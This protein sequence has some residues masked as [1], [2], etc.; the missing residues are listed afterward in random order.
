VDYIE[1]RESADGDYVEVPVP[2]TPVA[3]D[4]AQD[5]ASKTQFVSFHTFVGGRAQLEY[6]RHI[7]LLDAKFQPIGPQA[8]NLTQYLRQA[9]AANGSQAVTV[10][11]PQVL[12]AS[13]GKGYVPANYALPYT[14]NATNP[15]QGP[16]GEL[17]IVT[18]LDADL[19]VRSLRLGD[20]KIGNINVHLPD[21]QAV[22]QGDFDFTGNLGLVLRVSAGIDAET[23]VATWLIQAIDP[24]T[25]EVLHDPVRGLLAPDS[26]NAGAQKASVSYTVQASDLA[27]TGAQ[28]SV[29]ARALFDGLPPQDS[30]S[31]SLTLDAKAP[32]T[33]LSAQFAGND[34]QGGAT[35]DVRW[36]AVDDA[37]GVKH[38]TVYVAEEGGD[39]RIWRKQVAGAAGNA[40]FT[41][42]AGKHYEFLA[43]ATDLA[44]NREAA[45]VANA[46]LP[47]D[48]SQQA[49][50]TA[51]GVLDTVQGSATLP[52]AAPGRSY[53]TNSLFQS[54]SQA[55]PGYVAT[56]QPA[57]LQSVLAPLALRGLASGFAASEADIGVQA[58]VELPDGS[59]LASAGSLR[60]QV[61]HFDKAGGRSTT[62]LFELDS[63]ILDLALDA[64]GQLWAMTGSEL[65]Q[66]DATSGA[67]LQ[68]TRSS[69]GDPLT[70]ALAI[71]PASGLFYVSSGNGVETYNAATGAWTHFSNTRVIDLAF[72]PDGRLW[73]VRSTGADV[74]TG[75]PG[76]TTELISFPMSGKLKGRA[77]VEYTLAGNVQAIAFGQA[78]TPLAGL[79]LASTATPQRPV[80]TDGENLPHT[81]SLWAIEL[82]SHRLLKLASG[83]TRQ[84]ALVATADGRILV[85]ES[86]RIDEIA[87]LKAPTVLAA[88]VADGSVL[89]LPLNQVSIV[90]DQAM[91]LGDAGD[92]SE[93]GSVLNPANYQLTATGTNAGLTLA[94]TAVR[95]DA[96]NHAVVLTLP[97]LAAGGWELDV[98]NQLLSAAG[99]P[100]AAT[101]VS[102]FTAVVDMSNA[103]SIAFSNTRANRATGEVSYD[104]SITNIGVDDIHGPL[105]LLLDPGR[106]FGGQIGNASALT[107]DQSDLWLI[108]LSTG[109]TGLGGKLAVGATLA[110]QTVSVTPASYFGTGVSGLAK[111]NLG[112]GLYAVPY[113]NTP[114]ALSNADLDDDTGVTLA[115]ATLGQPY[116]AQLL[117]TDTDG[118]QF[119]W[120][121][122]QGPAGLTLTPGAVVH[123]AD[124]S[125]SQTAELAWTPGANA[126]ANT[127]VLVRV[128]DSRGGTDLKR[129]NI[130]VPGGN[131]AP[132]IDAIS[133]ITLTEGQSL[134]QRLTASDANGD[135]LS[136]TVRNLPAG[137]RFNAATGMLSWTPSYDQAGD[138]RDV[139]VVVSD[140]KAVTTR[141]FNIHVDQGYPQPVLA[142]VPA[143][144][145][146][147]GDRFGLQLSGQV[148]G[149]LAHADGS[150]ITLSFDATWLP[151]GATLNSETGWFEWTPGYAQAGSYDVPISLTATFTPAD[152][153]EPVTTSVASVLHLSVANANG[154]PVFDPVETWTVLEGQALRVSLF[155]FDPDNPGFAPKVRL[156][157]TAPAVDSEGSTAAS[158]SYSVTGLPPGASFD[159]DTLELV[160]TPGYSQA[161][162]Y[163]IN[164]TATD[165]GNGIGVPLSSHVT[166]PITVLNANR[167]PDI[168]AI[169][170]ATLDAGATLDIPVSATDADGN[171]I[172]LTIN[173]LPSF[174]T[175]TQ[176]ANGQGSLHFAPPAGVRGDYTVT[177]VANDNGDGDPNQ[178]QAQSVSFVLTVRSL[179]MPPRFTLPTSVVAVAGQ[180]LSLP[181]QVSDDDQDALSIIA[182]GLPTGAQLVRNAQYGSATLSWTPTAA[183]LGSYNV[184]IA[185]TDSGLPPADNGTILDPAFVP[186]PNTTAHDLRI[187]VRAANAAASLIA[188]SAT[189]ATLDAS[190]LAG[191]TTRVAVDEGSAMTFELVARDPDLDT[192]NWTATGLPT[193]MTLETTPGTDG[194]SQARLRWT[195]GIFGAQSGPDSAHPGTYTITLTA[196]DGNASVSRTLELTVRNVNQA[197]IVLPMP[198]QLVQEGQT[199]S[200]TVR[201]Y[202]ADGDATQL[203]LVHDAN[204]PAGVSFDAGS[205]TFEWT[206][207]AGIVNN[208]QGNARN[209][210]FNF[211]ISDGSVTTTRA[212]QVRVL[213][214]N[215]PPM[216][217]ASSHALVVGQS[218][219]LPVQKLKRN[220]TPLAGAIQVSDA[221][222][223][224]QTQTLTVAFENLPEGASFDAASG[225]LRW[226]PGPGQVGDFVVLA[227]VSDGLN[228]SLES[229]TLRVVANDDAALRANSPKV[230][231]N[232]TPATPALP[233]QTVV[234]TVRASSFSAI[235]NV[236]VQVRGS[237]LGDALNWQPA[238]LDST[239][240]LK[241]VPTL[242]GLIEVLVTA[243]DADSFTTTQTQTVRV[244]DP[245]DNAA[246]QLAWAG[247]L[248]GA[249]L[250]AAP[251]NLQSLTALQA[252]LD[253]AQLMGWR[254]EIASATGGSTDDSSWRLLAQ[255]DVAAS[256][257]HSVLDLASLDPSLLA[258][259]VYALRLSAWDL[260]GRTTELQGRVVIDS[261][262]KQLTQASATD[263][264]FQLG[265]HRFDL[266]RSL[267]AGTAAPG[268]FGNWTLPALSLQLSHDQ[269]FTT[270]L[271][272]TAPWSQGARVWLQMPGSADQALA[273]TLG[274]QTQALGNAPGTPTTQHPVFIAAAGTPAG[275]TLQA[276]AG[277]TASDGSQALADAASVMPDAVQHQG[278]R[279]FDADSGL[280]W[281]P[282]SYW[283]TGPDGTRYSLDAQGRVT[284]MRF[285]DGQAWIVSDAGLTLA[286]AGATGAR[287][288]FVRNA[289]GQIEQV[290]GQDAQGNTHTIVYRY[291]AQGRL[292]L[293]REL[294]AAGTGNLVGYH[295]DGSLIT[296]AVNVNF[297]AAVAWQGSSPSNAWSGALAS[298]PVNFAYVVRDSE[299]ASTV[300]AAG[301]EGSIVLALAVQGGGAL[302]LTQHTGS[303]LLA[304][305]TQ[306]GTTTYLLRTTQAGMQ[307]LSLTG[308]GAAQVRISV[309]GD[310][311]Q[312]GRVDGSDSA[313]FELAMQAGSIATV[314]L[315]GDG[316]GN[317]TDR[318]VLYA[319]YG[320]RANQAPF[321]SPDAGILG[322]HANL[323]VDANG[324]AVAQDPE[325]DRLFW[326]IL[327]ATHGTATL[328][329]DGRTI[330]FNPEAGYTGDAEVSLQ[331][332]DGYALSAPIVLKVRVSAAPLLNVQVDR[333]VSIGVGSVQAMR[334]RGDYADERGV[335]LPGGYAQITSDNT[336]V[337]TVD[338]E[339]YLHGLKP[340]I[341]LITVRTGGLTA[342]NVVT[343]GSNFTRPNTD[344]NGNEL[345]LYPGSIDL[346][347]NGGQ[348]QVDVHLLDGSYLGADVS[349][350][351]AGTRY[352]ISDPRIADISPDGNVV[353]KASGTATITVVRGG[354]QGRIELRVHAANVGPTVA[355]I[356][357]GVVTQDEQG[358]T[359]TIGANAL[360]RNTMAS[361]HA[362][363]FSDLSTPLPMSD[364]LPAL[365][366]VQVDLQGA[367]VSVPLQ[368]AIK[369][370]AGIDPA[371][372]RPVDLAPG[373]E[374]L[375]WQEG[376]VRGA[377]GV[378]HNVW[379]LVDNGFI[380]NDGIA[381]TASPPYV[382]AKGDGKFIVTGTPAIDHETGAQKIPAALVNTTAW[383][384]AAA[385][386][387]VA[388]N[389]MMAGA[390]LSI[391]A[392]RSNV[393]ALTYT[394]EGAYQVQIPKG[395]LLPGSSVSIPTPPDLPRTTPAVTQVQYNPTSREL[396]VSGVNFVPPGQAPENFTLK[397]WLVPIGDQIASVTKPGTAPV[398]GLIWQAFDVTPQPDGSLHLVLPAGVALSQHDVYVERA[399]NASLPPGSKVDPVIVK[400]DPA[401]PTKPQPPNPEVMIPTKSTIA[402]ASTTGTNLGAANLTQDAANAA[403][404]QARSVWQAQGVNVSVLDNVSIKLDALSGNALAIANGNVITLSSDAAH[405]GWYV[406]ADAFN[407]SNF[408]E[409][410]PGS[411]QLLATASSA[412][413]GRIDL[414]TTL[415]EQVGG[416]LGISGNGSAESVMNPEL[417][418]GVRRLP[419]ASDVPPAAKGHPA[420]AV[421]LKPLP[422]PTQTPKADPTPTS[423]AYALTHTRAQEAPRYS[424]LVSVAPT[425]PSKDILVTTADTIDIFQ[426]ATVADPSANPQPIRI[427]QVTR[428][429]QGRKLELSGNYA[430]QI[431]FSDDGSLAFIAGKGNRIYVF[432]T[433]T[434]D[435]VLTYEVAGATTA[436]NSL[437][438]NGE[439]LYIAEGSNYGPGGGRLAR[440]NI[441]SGPEFFKIFQSLSIPGAVAPLGFRDMAVNSGRYLAITAPTMSTGVTRSFAGSR[442]NVYLIDLAGVGKSSTIDIAFVAQLDLSAYPK[443][444]LGKGPQYITSASGRGQFLLSDSKDYDYGTAA[445]TFG[446]S[447]IDGTPQ[448]VATVLDP[449]LVPNRPGWLQNKYQQNIQ[450]SA[451][452]VTLNYAGKTY[453]LVADYNFAW[454]D[455]HASNGDAFGHQIGGKIGVIEDPFGENGEPIYLGATTP[456][457]GVALDH[458]MLDQSGMLYVDGFVEDESGYYTGNHASDIMYRSLFV[459]NASQL[460][461]AA[462]NAKGRL[463]TIPID[464]DGWGPTSNQYPAATPARYDTAG[465]GKLFGWIYGV[466]SYSSQ[467]A[468]PTLT[469]QNVPDLKALAPSVFRTAQ[470]AADRAHVPATPP[471]VIA[472]STF[473]TFAV[474][475]MAQLVAFGSFAVGSFQAALGKDNSEMMAQ[476]SDAQLILDRVDYDTKNGGWTASF[477]RAT[478]GAL[479]GLMMLPTDFVGILARDTALV[480]GLRTGVTPK[481]PT[482]TEFLQLL[483]SEPSL[484]EVIN[485]AAIATLKYHPI[486]LGV[487]TIYR[488]T[489]AAVKKDWED[490]RNATAE[491]FVLGGLTK[492]AE[493]PAGKR[494]IQLKTKQADF[495][496]QELQRGAIEVTPIKDLTVEPTGTQQYIVEPPKV[497]GSGKV[498]SEGRTVAAEEFGKAM[499]G[500]FKEGPD[501]KIEYNPRVEPKE[502]IELK[503]RAKEIEDTCFDGE[504]LVHIRLNEETHKLMG[505]FIKTDTRRSTDIGVPLQCEIWHLKPGVE[506]LSKC[507]A[508]GEVAYRKITRVYEHASQRVWE[509]TYYSEHFGAYLSLLVTGN[510]PFWVVGKGWVNVIDLQDGD[511]FITTDGSSAHFGSLEEYEYPDTVYNIEVE[512]FHTYF[513]GAG[514]LVHNK[515]QTPSVRPLNKSE[516][517]GAVAQD[518]IFNGKPHEM[519]ARDALAQA[520]M[521]NAALPGTGEKGPN[522]EKSPKNVLGKYQ[523]DAQGK[524][525]TNPDGS[526]KAGDP[527]IVFTETGE[528]ADLYSPGVEGGGSLPTIAE[529]VIKK[530]GRQASTI[531]VDLR[532][533]DGVAAKDV[534]KAVDEYAVDENGNPA[535]PPAGL[536]RLIIIEKDGA[537]FI[538]EYAGTGANKPIFGLV[539]LGTG[540]TFRLTEDPA[541]GTKFIYDSRIGDPLPEKISP[542][543]TPLLESVPLPDQVA[544]QE[545]LTLTAVQELFPAARQY[546]LAIGASET[547]LDRIQIGV[548]RLPAGQAGMIEGNQITLSVDGAG[549]GWF[550]DVTPTETEEFLS[551]GNSQDFTADA[552]SAAAGK[553]DL[554][555]VLIHEM[556]HALGLG[557]SSQAG[558]VMNAVLT[559]GER[560][561]PGTDDALG[562]RGQGAFVET[563]RLF[564]SRVATSL[565]HA[566]PAA[567]PQFELAA[568]PQ[569]TNG[570]FGGTSAAR[571]TTSGWTTSGLVMANR[572]VATLAEGAVS[573]TQLSQ[574][575]HLGAND[576]FL[577]FTVVQTGLKLNAG[578]PQDAFEVALL[579]ASTGLPA[580]RDGT[581]T[582]TTGLSH[583]DALLNLQSNGTLRLADGVHRQVNA[584]GSSTY[585]LD[586]PA[587]LAEQDLM[588]SF[589]LLGFGQGADASASSV[590]IRDVHLGSALAAVDD[591]VPTAVEDTPLSVN[592]LANDQGATASTTTVQLVQGPQHGHAA[593]GA[594][595]QVLYTPDANYFGADSFSYQLLDSASGQLSNVATVSLT[596]AAVNDAPIAAPDTATLGEDDG[597]LTVAAAQGVLQGQGASQAGQDTDVESDPLTV[598]GVAAGTPAAMPQSDVGTAVQGTYGSLTLAADGAYTYTL[599][600]FAQSLA[601]GATGQDQFTYTVSDGQ[602]GFATSTLTLT[603][604]GSNDAAVI[605]GAVTGTVTEDVA[606]TAADQL[607]VTDP[608]AGENSFQVQ[609]GTAG[610]YG[611]MALS[612]SGLWTYTLND[613]AAVH[614]LIPGQTVTDSF[615]VSSVDGATTTVVVTIRGSNDAPTARADA[616]TL[617][618][619]TSL[620]L[621][622][623]AGLIQNSGGQDTD[624]DA[625]D[626]LSVT[627]VVA[628]TA[629]AAPA[630]GVGASVTGAYGSLT[631]AADG[632]AT[633]VT[634]QGAQ[635]LRAGSSASD[636]FTYAVTDSRGA[637]SF[638][639]V[640]FNVLGAN[641]A[642][643]LAK[644]VPNQVAVIGQAYSYTVP[645]DTVSDVDVG[646]T[647]SYSATL[648]NGAALPAWLK[649]NAATRTFSGTPAAADATTLTV[650]LTASD[651]SASVFTDFKLQARNIVRWSTPTVWSANEGGS[652]VWKLKLSG[653]SV[654]PTA[655]KLEVISGTG[656]VGIDTDNFFSNAQVS[657]DGFMTFGNA[658]VNGN[659]LTVPPGITTVYIVI[660]TYMDDLVESTEDVQLKITELGG[661]GYD[662]TPVLST[663]WIFNYENT[664]LVLDLDGDGVHTGSFSDGGRF[665]LSDGS[666]S[667]YST[668]WVDGRDGLLALD[669][670][671][672]GVIDNG[673]ELFGSGTHLGDGSRAADGFQALAQ[674]DSNGDGNIDAADTVFGNL[675]VW[676]DANRDGVTD[677]GELRALDQAG[678]ASIRL[679]S[680]VS[681]IIDNGNL[682]GRMG[683][684]VT[685]DG[686]V[687]D[688]ADVWFDA[689]PAKP[690]A[691]NPQAGQQDEAAD[692][693]ANPLVTRLNQVAVP[694]SQEEVAKLFMAKLL[695]DSQEAVLSFEVPPPAEAMASA[696]T[697]VA[698]QYDEESDWLREME[699]A[700]GTA[701]KEM[702]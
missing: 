313:A 253:E 10:Q 462:I 631:V 269:P 432:D 458:M 445:I 433:M 360:S 436:I 490:F 359:L 630:T 606:V 648:A 520:G 207:D 188:A 681:S 464:R 589:D 254:L 695:S 222:G 197:P 689:R 590:S 263:A 284:G 244:R 216:I 85:G 55:L 332:D 420:P 603:V 558:D 35:Y 592:V 475:T 103:L 382:A 547:A 411:G 584:D 489:A 195:P 8:L 209:F 208:D 351:S 82:Q 123:E 662:A 34:A 500:I 288:E 112:H 191:D 167:A 528:T 555:T 446:L 358:N 677:A 228:T 667:V 84:Q 260:A 67:I 2:K 337:V 150:S 121:V 1:G 210:T 564:I 22:F 149:G 608:D 241:L 517:P 647:L 660:Q 365:A 30:V 230:L 515:N 408:I 226:T 151:G 595:G 377:D 378:L 39:F 548:G 169:A 58:L 31:Q 452:S 183:Q 674:Y 96:A 261:S 683:S 523:Y 367:T 299:L 605:S 12:P 596:I 512:E 329:A 289:S 27:V 633:Y 401:D 134:N 118:A 687:R 3:A 11:G 165:D 206:P 240:R 645:A 669:L 692:S 535:G 467:Q 235:A 250:D 273:F 14:I 680:S 239:G 488:M 395:A 539:D 551:D 419:S 50:Q 148:P 575:F 274:L 136:I 317:A 542:N 626:T 335:E 61:F 345:D 93:P 104:V 57:D 492:W 479:G 315:D 414:L 421:E 418:T 362:V 310:L 258:N 26:K 403:L 637:T 697:P 456:I 271:G 72:G 13:D 356:E 638:T 593:V 164:V 621:S 178:V 659:I 101:F 599:N 63:P 247:A 18:Q 184:S 372:G 594:D 126:L 342:Y 205:G 339:G 587:G 366:A 70:H 586:L 434:Q 537:V 526:P 297:G 106:Y 245:Q 354:L 397:V 306:G 153:S 344:L 484:G 120:Q 444:N 272:T 266:S 640:T 567:R 423:F 413:E 607:T 518:G 257:T 386:A 91:W 305:H 576:R 652:L 154:A 394:I 485:Y 550:V 505:Q 224:A 513:V 304:T 600:A 94:P 355:T 308:S 102:K 581:H 180:L 343:V 690:V 511:Q 613:T 346:A 19:D 322:T 141:R 665:D 45:N 90:F 374:V 588:L 509:L 174:A 162:T 172:T 476:W 675:L 572:G 388:P 341:A 693:E 415:L 231:V 100:L 132:V 79:L 131:F 655:T 672:N 89:P 275:W 598:V 514:I 651:G 454:A 262:T 33:T 349:A 75:A 569:L 530:S 654:T 410:Y 473:Q 601:A 431:V 381:R 143:Q 225:H 691:M 623:T 43:T 642:P 562:L 286:G 7:G 627:G 115:A 442:G 460:V 287:V 47:D 129:F 650:R 700:A 59:V 663:A 668:G 617:M 507:E 214:V 295:A 540:K 389:P 400:A 519:R 398:N 428:D 671:G 702:A 220:D 379:W 127:E 29:Q 427:G 168:G 407:D 522:G 453:A 109:L 536:R 160:W 218:F 340:G 65:L 554:L 303:T 201:G 73:G 574:L 190:P 251:I 152:G 233:G 92:G 701:L 499:E 487:E 86:T 135:N 21:S 657:L 277:N 405:W 553:L 461:Q 457:V 9:A 451:G 267:P 147:E 24:D 237:A 327:G 140:G 155:A 296:D 582:G 469:L 521:D 624:A 635:S 98:S 602:G 516:V 533:I 383:I 591:T 373:S 189:G 37:S 177:V 268:D 399:A 338:A 223:D 99:V 696:A 699:R 348:R 688:V 686:S 491:L 556:G 282:G 229:F 545:A 248:A 579:N 376:E 396:V 213:D 331:A 361:I 52:A 166:L 544:A 532:G 352:L 380:G 157:P 435:I 618:E 685:T 38:V 234:A 292:M 252:Q 301:A 51:L 568:N 495:I 673:S 119:F 538:A 182:N 561:L 318:Q 661:V 393:T 41:G 219:D 145:L 142:S 481:V 113:Q 20:L 634:G 425:T 455:V 215:R 144:N 357:R 204:L 281:V 161:G 508:T 625:N 471:K 325:G 646:D 246:P 314:D 319:N 95:W 402:F 524:L 336:D 494:E 62:P 412:A 217:T 534:V 36:N 604:V 546:W 176:G 300:K 193:G 653:P 326:R 529:T 609:S 328:Q 424:R 125:Y 480:T 28:V 211:A 156:S 470:S 307:L 186:A 364:I 330:H 170:N 369:V 311:N 629:S 417:A 227:R 249:G 280:A 323:S 541:P 497:D 694:P 243:T 46:V 450:R 615:T 203:A 259:G 309:A 641:D 560:R 368:L 347:A 53:A 278:Q 298:T 76:A 256:A 173:G 74:N 406:G 17:R 320:W 158:V 163:F 563:D 265:N 498:I 175:F 32:V 391:F 194:Q 566:A 676:V 56:A 543:G 656:T 597:S 138:Y 392:S 49:A 620:V 236:A 636:V 557:H 503:E 108:D 128:T 81:S 639:T 443:S 463:Q 416:I 449:H 353:A 483:S 232:L 578:G 316:Q 285:A 294:F 114:P 577:T 486:T 447:P 610:T 105:M 439:W 54:A 585:T 580:L 159:A 363:A 387:A 69:N 649:F 122:V 472:G 501:G 83:G 375:F 549:W 44:G 684:F 291:D 334:V 111:F 64:H 60:N 525:K 390:A 441:G 107:G 200:F 658:V 66:L 448:A 622:A 370:S 270:Q 242:P 130:A 77:E 679:G 612:A 571:G 16:V 333:L 312:D 477:A 4:Y 616:Y 290:S 384:E 133:D 531:V 78:G 110:D 437:A 255:A 664:P 185:V 504:T 171:P 506:V 48:G 80:V 179:T 583:S 350:S 371:T 459:W 293:T 40:L 698:Q 644:A 678:V 321:A 643:V 670:N 496:K 611:S 264:S 385:F 422:E 482:P 202:D 614:A 116:T 6:L 493:T 478:E 88:S 137:A 146:R 68:R 552:G 42:V 199:L 438:V 426:P 192:L 682:L 666:R 87:P 468:T 404:L 429:E 187:V 23:R 628:G 198:L 196:G 279:L 565:G 181:I 324:A 559:P 117:A 430:H 5:A 409:A 71:D 139:T 570:D 573:Q 502:A 440:V 632:S 15:S 510:H 212:V 25:G 466:G 124:G 97:N 238:T 619:D 302:Q 221:D 527:D 474:R 465:D 283:L 276:F